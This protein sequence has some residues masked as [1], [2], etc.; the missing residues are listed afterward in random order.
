MHFRRKVL[1]KIMQIGDLLLMGIVFLMV[2][3]AFYGHNHTLLAFEEFLSIRIKIENIL[4]GMAMLGLWHLIFSTLNLYESKR[5]STIIQEIPDVLK[6]TSLVTLT[7][8]GITLLIS[9]NMI[10][11]WFLLAFWVSITLLIILSRVTA[12]KTLA[13]MRRKG[14]NLRN[15]VIIGTNPRALTF[16]KEIRAKP[17]LG[18][19]LLGF[20][21]EPWEGFNNQHLEGFP[22]IS[23]LEKFQGFIRTFS[24]DE[25]LI[26]LPLRS[27]YQQAA[28]IV[29]QCEEQGILVRMLG[30]LFSP[31]LAKSALDEVGPHKTLLLNTG[32][33]GDQAHL[34]KRIIDILLALPSLLILSPFFVLIALGIKLT[35]PGPILFVQKRI[36][37]NKRPFNLYKFRSMVPDA[38]SML[39]SLEPLNEA[40]GAAFKIAND[41][42][43]TRFG[44]LLRK[45]SLDEFPQLL[46]VLKGDMSL[47]GPR[48]IQFRDFEIFYQDYHR[49]RFSVRPGLT[50]LWQVGGRSK[51]TFEQWM[52][53]DLQYIDKWTLWLDLKILFKTLPAVMKGTGAA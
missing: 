7:T 21:D 25:V 51:L 53:L 9:I 42:R 36:G 12:R 6:A 49:R 37:F 31:K 29:E 48:P 41:P 18:Y 13:W 24:V 23:D 33:I 20:V 30:D 44:K 22:L 17:D 8:A 15:I 47:V 35:S 14:R 11:F 38:E 1:L 19:C 34:I 16:A 43:L 2:I 46:N 39:P 3:W 27:Y 5:L 40:T 26:T 10:S 50:C 45:T 32:A 52:E 4:L 28:K